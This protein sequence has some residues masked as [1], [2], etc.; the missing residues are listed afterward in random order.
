MK[1]FF[2]KYGGWGFLCCILLS[3]LGWF[4]WFKTRPVGDLVVTLSISKT[5]TG[6][7]LLHLEIEKQIAEGNLKVQGKKPEYEKNEDGSIVFLTYRRLTT[8]PIS[9]VFKIDGF[10]IEEVGVGNLKV[11]EGKTVE[12]LVELF[13]PPGN[14]TLTNKVGSD[15][16]IVRVKSGVIMQKTMEVVVFVAFIS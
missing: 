2:Q 14:L 16:T 6:G 10:D 15:I 9:A 13:D 3:L 4:Y 1:G 12:Q 8:G 11:E 7:K 5:Y